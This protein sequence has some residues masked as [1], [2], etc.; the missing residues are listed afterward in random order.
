MTA[1]ITQIQPKSIISDLF[2]QIDN[3]QKHKHTIK[4]VSFKIFSQFFR[5]VS[6]KESSSLSFSICKDLISVISGDVICK[7]SMNRS[8]ALEIINTIFA[9]VQE[10]IKPAHCHTKMRCE[11][12]IHS[13]ADKCLMSQ[14]FSYKFSAHSGS[15]AWMN[16]IYADR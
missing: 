12:T 13:Q 14:T 3:L 4:S 8:H 11:F 16:A 7:K 5:S 9:A 6:P 10:S 2:N 1:I 15:K